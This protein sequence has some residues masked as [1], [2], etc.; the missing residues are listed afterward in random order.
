MEQREKFVEHTNSKK[1]MLH[2]DTWT[3]PGV[4]DVTQELL[5]NAARS[6]E[7]SHGTPNWDVQ[8]ARQEMARRVAPCVLGFYMHFETT[9]VFATQSQGAPFNVFTILVAEE[10]LELFV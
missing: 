4:R 8:K 3:A 7:A 2:D 5:A 1:L 6:L 10:R 9:E